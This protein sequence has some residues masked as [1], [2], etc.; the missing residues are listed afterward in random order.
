MA[1]YAW[2]IWY[3]HLDDEDCKILGPRNITAGQIE[4]LEEGHGTEFRLYDD[5]GELYL[6]GL[7]LG[8]IDS[9]DAFGPLDDYGMPAAGC[10]EIRYQRDGRFVTL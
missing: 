8:D 9:E 6:S 3:D 5:D 1:R 10:T 4:S 7:F 2:L